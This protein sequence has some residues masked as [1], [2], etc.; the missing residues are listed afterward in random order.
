MY[1]YLYTYIYIYIYI[2]IYT[3]NHPIFHG[4]TFYRRNQ[5][6]HDQFIGQPAEPAAARQASL[7]GR[8]LE[9]CGGAAASGHPCFV[10]ILGV[11]CVRRRTRLRSVLLFYFF[12]QSS[13]FLS[14]KSNY[15]GFAPAH[16][17]YGLSMTAMFSGKKH[18]IFVPP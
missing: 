13:K 3:H 14:M 12:G 4:Q 1:I 2:Y 7:C 8:G 5:L 18:G 6:C 16:L 17:R 9:K 10:L 15:T 11:L